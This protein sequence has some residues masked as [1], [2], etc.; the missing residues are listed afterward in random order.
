[1]II[2][3]LFYSMACMSLILLLIALNIKKKE[4]KHE[5]DDRLPHEEVPEIAEWHIND[6]IEYKYPKKKKGIWTLTENEEFYYAGISCLVKM[7][8]KA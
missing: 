3:I 6:I 5:Y 4:N 2:D 7:V 8:C 1:M